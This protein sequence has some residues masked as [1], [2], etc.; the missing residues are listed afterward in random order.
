MTQ[1]T[2][3]PTL[4]PTLPFGFLLIAA[5]LASTI[6]S[7]AERPNLLLITVD[8]MSADSVGVYGCKLADTTPGMDAF[9]KTAMRFQHA[10]VQVGN[11]MPG[12]NIMWSGMYSHKNGV[13]GF[14]QNRHA[15]YPVLCDLAKSAG[16]FTAIRGKGSHSTP[17]FPYAWDADVT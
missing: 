17:Y 3:R 8:D 11:C 16:Y 12:R 1:N 9:A 2:F 13:E 15:D 5:C 10:H 14:V 7:G 6:A 4:R